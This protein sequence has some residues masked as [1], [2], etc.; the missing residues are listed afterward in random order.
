MDRALTV[1][2]FIVLGNVARPL[3][4]ESPLEIS[5]RYPHLAMFNHQGEC[6]TGA[7][8]PWAGRLWVITYGPHLP[9][10]SDDKLY[11][12]DAALRRVTRPE[13]V[14]GTPANRL[15]HRESRQLNIGP[16]FID[17]ERRVRA[18]LPS[19]MYGRLTATARHLTDPANKVYVCDMEGL[20][21]EVDVRSL[22]V[23]LLFKR[24]VPGWHGKGGYTGQGRLVLAY[25]GEHGTASVDR[26]KPF[27]AFLDPK[28]QSAEDAGSLCEWDGKSWRLIERRQFTEVTGPGGILGAPDDA[29]PLW[30][31]GWDHRS[32]ILKLLDGGRWQTFRLPIACYSYMGR[33]GWHTEW[34]RIRE[35]GQGRFL[36]NMHG[37]W[38]DFPPRF[39]SRN[40]GGL[41]PLGTYLKITGDFCEWNGRVVFGCDDTAKSAFLVTGVGDTQNRLVGQSNSNLW[42]TTWEGLTQAGRPAGFGGPWI[43]DHV[44]AGMPSP[45]YLFAGYAQ[46]VLHLAHGSEHPVAFAVEIDRS[47]D[48]RWTPYQSISVKPGGYAY[49]I[50]PVGQE[51]QWV[52][53]VPD[54]DAAGVTAFFHYGPGGGVAADRAMF[55]ALADIDQPGPWTS[56]IVR[57]EGEDRILLGALARPVDAAGNVGPVHAYQVDEAMVFHPTAPESDSA[58]FL[59]ERAVVRD[60]LIETDE[61]SVIV[62][63]GKLRFRLPKSHPAYDAPW[64]T[65]WPRALREVVTERSLLNA[66]GTFYVLPRESSGGLRAIRP[67][68][69]HNKRITDFCSWRG[70]LVLAGCVAKAPADGHYFASDD[71][72][73]LWIG[74]IDDLW[75]LGKPVGRGGPWLRTPVQ[76]GEVSDPY[77]MA[78]YDRKKVELSHDAEG[79]VTFT[80]LVDV[81]AGDRWFPYA[82]IRVPSGR[83]VTHV[84]PSGYS[85]HWVRLKADRRCRAT[86]LFAYE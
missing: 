41:R 56:A 75:K 46:R 9:E 5:G 85:A 44:K 4:A 30:S 15:I 14:G 83:G 54:R 8:V 28:P 82:T 42:F 86:A 49:C 38:F 71:G 27:D 36:M 52:R 25:N 6:G 63:E 24:P 57:S 77:L 10:G 2:A 12:I 18:I 62:T 3:L 51:G 19:K 66:A 35:V 50:F 17:A 64:N 33:H 47:G 69:T 70:L 58:R 78:G 43:D 39:S 61:A 29:A 55:S 53:L 73:G 74:D 1:I 22:D 48:G 68:C 34:P 67:I 21:Y 80:I 45:P 26:F 72:M 59:K 65:G 76:A 20:I 40:T 84:F 23:K 37:G 11:E 13:S 81:T 7:V 16:Y 32:L 60:R 31:I 79:D